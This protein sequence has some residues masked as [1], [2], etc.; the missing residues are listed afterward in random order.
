MVIQL[1]LSFCGGCS[2]SDFRPDEGNPTL[3]LA[4]AEA[5]LSDEG[6]KQG[7]NGQGLQQTRLT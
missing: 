1:F 3:N 2:D 7:S 4:L 6:S 5:E